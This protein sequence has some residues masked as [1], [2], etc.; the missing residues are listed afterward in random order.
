MLDPVDPVTELDVP[1]VVGV[2]DEVCG[3]VVVGVVV[4]A[5]LVP[6]VVSA[7]ELP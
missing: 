5:A 3:A 1:E 4:P 6:E 7:T 2:V